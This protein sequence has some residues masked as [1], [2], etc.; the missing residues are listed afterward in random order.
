MTAT[1][2]ALSPDQ[3]CLTRKPPKLGGC[4]RDHLTPSVNA[5]DRHG[6][7]TRSESSVGQL[8]APGGGWSG[9]SSVSDE[10]T[11]MHTRRIGGTEVSAIGLGGMPMSIEGR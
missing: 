4:L 6:C 5:I 7:S 10:R 8:K 1:T 9:S 11:T 2:N 3:A